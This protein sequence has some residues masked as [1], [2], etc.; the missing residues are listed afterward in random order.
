[1]TL[2]LYGRGANHHS[3]H[4]LIPLIR[5]GN[6]SDARTHVIGPNPRLKAAMYRQMPGGG[7]V[8]VG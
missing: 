7:A 4:V 6:T 8:T 1:M 5:R 2:L 3:N